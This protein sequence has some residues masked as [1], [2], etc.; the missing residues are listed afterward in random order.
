M[1]F[2][3]GF[4][5]NE[6]FVLEPPI[7]VTNLNASDLGVAPYDGMPVG[8][9]LVTN[10]YDG[11]GSGVVLMKALDNV[12]GTSQDWIYLSIAIGIGTPA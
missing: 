5:N 1:A 4:P 12:N 7:S 8:T 3:V 10:D 11:T 2:L 9:M 6:T